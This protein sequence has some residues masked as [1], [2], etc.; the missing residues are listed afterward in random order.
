VRASYVCA[1]LAMALLA[2]HYI[3]AI[4]PAW[5]KGISLFSG[6]LALAGSGLAAF[7]LTPE[8]WTDI[9]QWP[10]QVALGINALLAIAFIVAV[11]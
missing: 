1:V 8:G 5:T 10:A 9:E 6:G 11:R 3:A 7:A 2:S 4:L